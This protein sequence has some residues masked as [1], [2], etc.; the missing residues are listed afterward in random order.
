MQASSREEIDN[1]MLASDAKAIT[2]FVGC[3]ISAVSSRLSGGSITKL[4]G[5]LVGAPLSADSNAAFRVCH[6]GTKLFATGN[7]SLNANCISL[8][9]AF[10]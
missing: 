6:A 8:I 4:I 5:S 2:S 7:H 1:Q 9:I 3:N 10:L